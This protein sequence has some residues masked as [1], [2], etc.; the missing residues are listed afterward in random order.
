MKGSGLTEDRKKSRRD[1]NRREVCDL[2][3]KQGI[4]VKEEEERE[5]SGVKTPSLF[6]VYATAHT[7][8]QIQ[9]GMQ[10]IIVLERTLIEDI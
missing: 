9:G 4:Q 2:N 5:S 1:G 10:K 7:P 8:I 6:L 3:A